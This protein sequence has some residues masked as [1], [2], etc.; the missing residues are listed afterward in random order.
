MSADFN[1]MGSA[2]P[3]WRKLTKAWMYEGVWDMRLGP[4]PIH[5]GTRVPPE[6]L[7]AFNIVPEEPY[8]ARK[9]TPP[10]QPNGH[11]IEA[12]AGTQPEQ[13][14]AS[15]EP[16]AQPQAGSKAA[17]VVDVIERLA[18]EPKAPR[19]N[20]S[21]EEKDELPAAIRDGIS[22]W[23]RTMHERHEPATEILR[24]AARDLFELLKVSKTVY[25]HLQDASHQ[26]VVDALQEIADVGGIPPAEAQRIMGEGRQAA[27]H[28]GDGR[29]N[30]RQSG[31]DA[32]D[33]VA[34]GNEAV[35]PEDFHAYMPMHSYIY[36][37]SR[38]MW[39]AA[40]VNSRIPPIPLLDNDGSPV[41]D[42]KGK[43]KSIAANKWLDVHRPV[44][45]MTW[46]PGL[47]MVIPNRL[48]AEGGWVERDGN[49]CFNLYRPPIIKP[50]NAEEA[51]PWIEH[52][53]K[54]YGP[55]AAHIL[56]WLAHR[57]QR[58]QEK[59]NHALV[60]GG[61]QG[62][63]KDTIL[64]PIKYAVGP[65]NFV[66]VSPQHLLGRFN[67]FVK[68]VILRISEARD[69]GDVDRFHFYDHMKTYTAAPPDVLRVDE[70]N[71]REYSVFNCCGVIITTNHKTDGIFLPAD[72]RRHFVAWSDLDLESFAPNYWNRLYEW[73]ANGGIANVAA[74]LA[75]L[76]ISSFDPK[77]PPPKTDAFWAIVDA[78]RAPE[79]AELADVLD[80]L[81][82][83]NA[84][85][86]ARIAN[87][88]TGGFV[89]WLLERKNRR[90][91]PHRMEQCGYVPVRNETNKEGNWKVHG[92]RQVIY[93][94][95][96]LSIRDRFEAARNLTD[97]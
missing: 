23:Y 12:D 32:Q 7:K 82:N 67:G 95:N 74:Y 79:D 93:A 42:D 51:G 45:Q 50:G 83:P 11:D 2:P 10:P 53:R 1:G 64:E 63:G 58:P 30:V 34:P 84:V 66:E 94:K 24:L 77:R 38:E 60:L 56:N 37:P 28:E 13:P 88:A 40:S 89:T 59:I 33:A 81:G 55:D 76:D 65:W 19:S 73:Y 71:L 96:T 47:P 27:E 39:P 18:P 17:P 68:S 75:T 52:V 54:V 78:S 97:G 61:R 44:E 43:E 22:L 16:N 85:T 26:A 8:T 41:L 46:A 48:I 36:T 72:D 15:P 62:I 21:A 20:G 87:E 3:D 31:A 86:I 69:L 49:N 91:I 57:V 80:R 92:A 25:P 4:A 90:L 70:K 9:R 14:Q 35:G 5:I 6:I 29:T